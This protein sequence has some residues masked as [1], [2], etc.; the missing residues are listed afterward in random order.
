MYRGFELKLDRFDVERYFTIG[1][2]LHTEKKNQIEPILDNF[3]SLNGSLDGSKMQSNW[4]PQIEADIFI[5]HSH[6]DEK[7]AISLAGWLHATFGIESFIDSCIWGYANTL[8]KR[9]DDKY[10]V[11]DG[12]ETY[13]YE[14]RNYS[15][16]HV[17]MMLVNALSK[18]IDNTECIFFL[19]TPSA[20]TVKDIIKSKTNSPWI[21]AELSTTQIIRKAIPHRRLNDLTK[22]FSGGV[23]REMLFLESHQLNI[24]YTL[25]LNHLKKVIDC[26]L[27]LWKNNWNDL[28]SNRTKNPLDKLYQIIPV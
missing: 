1:L 10:C 16:S 27:K 15:T 12:G 14:E 11:N 25:D 17:H 6:K 22:S 18:M 21:Y 9:I 13:N 7:L 4:F 5:S 20:V 3:I 28:Q 24:E 23:I 2:K 8:L 26:D 19:S